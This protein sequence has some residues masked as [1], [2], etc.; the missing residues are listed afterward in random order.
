MTQPCDSDPLVMLPTLILVQQATAVFGLT[1]PTKSRAMEDA[2]DMTASP[3]QPCS[4][5][6][7]FLND[8]LNA[9]GFQDCAYQM[10]TSY[11]RMKD[12]PTF[13]RYSDSAARRDVFTR[14]EAAIQDNLGLD[15]L[16]QVIDA[17][18]FRSSPSGHLHN[19]ERCVDHV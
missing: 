8:L 12:H 19:R 6:A 18:G 3:P 11:H 10:L 15:E 14:I 1:H 7:R 9:I 5:Y 16:Q 2:F 17:W 4:D 13:Q